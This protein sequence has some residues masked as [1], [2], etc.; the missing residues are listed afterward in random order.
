M[1]MMGQCPFGGQTWM[2][3]HWLLGLHR[4]GHEVWYIEDSTAWPYDPVQNTITNDCRYAAHHIATSLARVG[5]KECWGYRL[6]D[7]ADQIYGLTAGRMNELFAACDVLLNITGGIDL[8]EEHL[9]APLRVYL[10]TDPV[11]AELRL[12]N[13]D[14]HTRQAFDNHHRL[15]TYGENYGA[16]DCGVPLNGRTYV[17][18]RQPIALD[19]WPMAFD[20]QAQFFTT[21]GNY[22]QNGS[23]VVYR[24]ETYHWS[25]HHEWEKFIELPRLTP[26][27]FRM[28]MLPD[29]ADRTRLEA[30]GWQFHDPFAMS[31][32]TFGAYPEF[33]RQSR[34]EF[35]VA[36][37]QNIRL[38]SGWFSERDVCYLAS[39]K[40]VVTQDTGFG[41]ALPTGVG[42]FAF[43]TL[44][45]VLAAINAINADYTRHCQAARQLAKEY[46]ECTGVARRLLADCG[47]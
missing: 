10:E 5:L 29:L 44:P 27:P 37:D 45:E 28:A 1:G 20:P 14:E 38:R 3:L 46:L 33:I 16:P 24:G 41:C 15:A 43:Q 13:G 19:H 39:G 47:V 36:K 26:Q 17:K 30:C 42:L 40:P 31:L 6:A 34:G 11:T 35:T 2:H 7:R 18:T 23:D 25:K 21:I 32:D 22:R 4:L 8:R 9:Q 12:A